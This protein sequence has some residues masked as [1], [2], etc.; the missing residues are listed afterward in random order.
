MLLLA[1]FKGKEDQEI[2]SEVFTDW[3]CWFAS[4]FNPTAEIY[5]I[6]LFEIYG[7]TYQEKKARLQE[8]AKRYQ[9]GN[10]EG[11]AWSEISMIQYFFEKNAKRFGLVQ[12]FRENGII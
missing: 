9:S 11:L 4:T 2:K 12:E 3:G 7:K 6:I 10:F 8:L 5:N 1:R